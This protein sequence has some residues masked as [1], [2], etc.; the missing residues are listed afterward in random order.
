MNTNGESIY[1]PNYV[2]QLFNRMSGSYERMNYITSFGFSIRWRKQFLKNLDSST[3]KLKIIDLLTGMG[4]TWGTVKTKFPNSEI[5]ALDFS[6]EMIKHA[7]Q[8]NDKQFSQSVHIIQKDV[9]NSELPTEYFDIIICA[10]GLKTFN[11]EQLNHLARETKRILKP[12]GQIAFVEVSKPNN[13]LL[14]YLY[15]FYLG[16]VIPIL[17]WLFLGNPREYKMLW[18][19]TYLFKDSIN[20]AEIFKSEGLQTKY[21]TYFFG[22]ASG[23][24]GYKKDSA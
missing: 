14:Y 6:D 8:K 5:Y 9:L 21:D 16:K 17:G 24:H 2:R 12:G 4:E 22:C 23:F 10:F 3:D 13:L 11:Q 1:D 7:S 18:K 19:Y 20:A 15:Q